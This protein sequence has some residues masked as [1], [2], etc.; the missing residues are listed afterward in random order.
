MT[1]SLSLSLSGERTRLTMTSTPYSCLLHRETFFS[2]Q[3]PEMMLPCVFCLMCDSHKGQP[4]GTIGLRIHG[5]YCGARQR[6]HH[7]FRVCYGGHSNLLYRACTAYIY[8]RGGPNP[9]PA[10]QLDA[11][12]RKS[13]VFALVCSD[14]IGETVM[15]S[16]LAVREL[17]KTSQE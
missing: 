3:K 10:R 13:L 8:A 14:D 15:P 7:H 1:R 9:H 17:G 2:D 4:K 12:Y 11:V 16:S 6:A 5:R